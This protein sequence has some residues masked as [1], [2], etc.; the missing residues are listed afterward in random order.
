[1]IHPQL[2][3]LTDDLTS[4]QFQTWLRTYIQQG[5]LDELYESR[6]TPTATSST[7]NHSPSQSG[8][9]QR[10][11]LY[12]KTNA[13]RE[14]E[15]PHGVFQFGHFFEGLFEQF[16]TEHVVAPQEF[17]RNPVHI[18]FT[19]D[20]QRFRGSTDPVISDKEGKPLVLTEC[21]TTSNLKYV[22]R[23]GEPKKSHRRQAH[24]YARG[25]Q[26]EYELESPPPTFF[27]YGDRNSLET[28]T[29][30]MEWDEDLWTDTLE[31]AGETDRQMIH[32]IAELSKLTTSSPNLDM[33]PYERIPDQTV[34]TDGGIAIDVNEADLEPA[35]L[36]PGN[37]DGLLGNPKL[38]PPTLDHWK[39]RNFD[40]DDDDGD[41]PDLFECSYCEFAARCGG[42]PDA[43]DNTDVNSALTDNDTL[44]HQPPI[45]FLPLTRYPEDAV[46]AHLIANEEVALTPT[47][48]RQHPCLTGNG[49]EP[50]QRMK[51]RY[52]EVPQRG[53]YDWVCP[54][55]GEQF[56][57]RGTKWDGD[58]NSPPESP[59][60][61]SATLR[62]PTP[63]E[64]LDPTYDANI[65]DTWTAAD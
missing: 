1:M 49:V 32:S 30:W 37:S 18:D 22:K 44:G 28:I 8:G 31:W 11:V 42:A 25:L 17:V 5:N 61:E 63:V 45:G 34:T 47:L 58:I 13:P 36:P 56:D 26:E 64:L 40:E 33:T 55:T 2:D 23:A 60:S 9:C 6:N 53:V 50:P 65:L 41:K 54:E 15:L 29:F 43:R 12:R 3:R 19:V 48:A 7:N 59:A 24:I 38:L 20:S 4:V 21:K 62:G 51:D 52:G 10:K 46:V 57:Y 39:H 35:G 27:I 16:L 14:T